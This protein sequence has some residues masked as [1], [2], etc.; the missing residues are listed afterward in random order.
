MTEEIMALCRAMGACEDQE[1][2]LLPLA[3]TEPALLAVLRELDILD[4]EE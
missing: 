1:E 3:Q 2:L 4:I